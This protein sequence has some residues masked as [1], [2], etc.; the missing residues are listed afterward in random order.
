MAEGMERTDR[1]QLILNL[2]GGVGI[3]LGGK[4]LGGFVSSKS[5]LAG[6]SSRAQG[7]GSDLC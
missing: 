6:V 4:P 2:L 5:R 3:S 1:R 7:A